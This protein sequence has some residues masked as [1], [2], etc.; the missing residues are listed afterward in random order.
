[1]RI[2]DDTKKELIFQATL[3]LIMTR[4]F[5]ATPMSLIAKEAGVAAGTIYLY[6]KNKETLLNQLY[7]NEKQKYSKALLTGYSDQLPVRLAFE[8][9]WNNSLNYQIQHSHEFRFIEQFKIS[10]FIEKVTVEEGHL[11]FKSANALINRAREERIVK[12][13][14][15]NVIVT[16]F[17]APISEMVKQH[18]HFRKE[19]SKAD[20]AS[21][22]QGCWDA[23]KS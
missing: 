5:N 21:T 19:I 17:F 23:I 13:I 22:L 9:M 11:F 7:L 15:N 14:P 8:L 12:D 3:K 10:P 16:L 1:M 4:G 6:F 2:K 20:R 18:L